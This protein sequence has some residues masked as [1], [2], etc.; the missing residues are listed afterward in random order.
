VL[1]AL[2]LPVLMAVNENLKRTC[3][4]RLDGLACAVDCVHG[5]A[6][7]AWRVWSSRWLGED[8]MLPCLLIT[9]AIWIAFCVRSICRQHAGQAFR[10]KAWALCAI[11][12]C[13]GE[14]LAVT[15]VSSR[16]DAVRW[17]AMMCWCVPSP[18]WSTFCC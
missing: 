6:S 11:V 10:V 9:M 12:W 3:M 13:A 2:R 17:G 4:R 8:C 1:S 7:V 14:R 15:L 18:W 5:G 16:K